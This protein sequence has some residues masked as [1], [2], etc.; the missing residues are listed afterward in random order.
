MAGALAAG[1]QTME[2]AP[3]VSRPVSRITELPGEILPYQSVAVQARI[4]GYVERVLVDRG[5]VVKQGEVLAELSAPEMQ[6]QI[7]EAESR[8]RAAE[9]ERKRAEAQLAAAQSTAE[10]LAKAA[11]TPGAI[12]GNELIQAR[13]QVEAAR[14]S[15]ESR[16]QAA[17]AAE[18][19]ARTQKELEGYLRITA[20]F[21]GVVTERLVHPG[22]L[23]GSGMEQVLLRIEQISRLRVV[24]AVPEEIAGGIA[25]GARVEFRVAAYPERAY[26]GIVARLSH[27][28]DSKTRTMAVELDAGNRDGSL[29][30]GMYPSVKWPVRRSRPGLFV[31]AASVV[32]TTERTFVVRSRNGLAEWVDVRKRAD[33]GDLVEVLGDLRPGDLVVRRA[34]DEIREG[35]RL[36]PARE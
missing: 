35:V 6:A 9:A 36:G 12:A 13:Q 17:A 8:A 16:R 2:L 25:A 20:P 11:E 32:T 18:N 10:R 24:V 21:E 15:V 28:L 22:A 33:E 27:S 1:A 31:P 34:T 5:S 26:W 19:A 14:A 4:R 3:V 30:P 7:A 23:V 29:S